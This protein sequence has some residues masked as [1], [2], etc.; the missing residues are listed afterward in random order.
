MF[1]SSTHYVMLNKKTVSK[2]YVDKAH[3]LGSCK[4]GKSGVTCRI[5]ITTSAT[6]TVGLALGA[7][8]GWASGQLSISSAKTQ[9]TAVSCTSPKLKKGQVFRA[10][11]R[12]TRYSYTIQ[13]WLVTTTGYVYVLGKSKTLYAFN[14]KKNSIYCTF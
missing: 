4:A 2:S 5:D 10:Y 3:P 9:S 11:P 14:P 6:R 8:R 12:G 1:A 13:K 7:T